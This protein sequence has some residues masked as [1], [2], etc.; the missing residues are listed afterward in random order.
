LN[1]WVAAIDVRLSWFS[2]PRSSCILWKKFFLWLALINYFWAHSGSYSWSRLSNNLIVFIHWTLH[3]DSESNYH[4]FPQL[5]F[6]TVVLNPTTV[7]FHR[8]VQFQMSSM[9]C[10]WS[11]N[12]SR[13]CAFFTLPNE[14]LAAILS[15]R[16]WHSVSCCVNIHAMT[17]CHSISSRLIFY[18]M[19]E[20]IIFNLI[21]GDC[22]RWREC[23]HAD[24][25]WVAE[26]PT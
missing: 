14:I 6:C 21:I 5:A 25:R 4:S 2:F 3:S 11:E 12:S 22:A 19:V 16:T 9:C 18:V 26:S 1:H 24:S 20:Q 7:H 17:I 13:L 15:I 8:A 10:S 23:S